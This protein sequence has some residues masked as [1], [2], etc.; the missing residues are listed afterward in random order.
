MHLLHHCSS[1]RYGQIPQILFQKSGEPLSEE[2]E[3]R[4]VRN[5]PLNC[6]HGSHTGYGKHVRL[7]DPCRAETLPYMLHDGGEFI[8]RSRKIGGVN[9]EEHFIQGKAAFHPSQLA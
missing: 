7:L 8:V 6:G 5:V 2:G 3:A 1:G 9:N 4:V